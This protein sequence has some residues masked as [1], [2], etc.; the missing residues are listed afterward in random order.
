MNYLCTCDVCESEPCV[1]PEEPEPWKPFVKGAVWAILIVSGLSWEWGKF[2]D[3][4][5]W[6]AIGQLVLAAINYVSA[7][8]IY[9]LC[10]WLWRP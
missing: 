8:A 6:P 1:C 4:G 2:Q 9:E 3:L 7:V 10:K 5:V